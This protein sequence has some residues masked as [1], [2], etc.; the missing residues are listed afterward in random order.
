M[1]PRS[2]K[3]LLRAVRA[4]FLALVG[5]TA[6]GC[7][8]LGANGGFGAAQVRFVHVSAGT[9]EVDFYVNGTAA[10]YGLNFA[11]YT[12]Y[13]PVSAG[14]ARLSVHRPGTAYALATV[15][16]AMSAGRQ[17]T[18]VVSHRPGTLEERIYPDQDTPAPE[19]HVALRVLNEAE[20][21]GALSVY[22]T[23]VHDGEAAG[24][25]VA[26]LHVV[27]DAASGYVD[28]AADASGS[29]VLTAT[30][31]QAGLN[32]PVGS[33][34]LKAGSGAV[35]TI[36]LA[37]TAQAGVRGVTGFALDDADPF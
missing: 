15:Q 33:L 29:Y 1:F 4:G 7:G 37:G 13:L 20:G 18:A 3:C 31:A 30:V 27:A 5:V 19:G 36:V 2:C 21:A 12:S 17:Y 26:I 14:T 11:S 9:P 8:S 23:P 34:T 16:T 10:A 32:V 24:N 28:V 22:V 6:T 25:P 35:R